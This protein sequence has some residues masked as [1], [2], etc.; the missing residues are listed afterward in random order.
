MSIVDIYWDNRINNRKINESD[1]LFANRCDWVIYRLCVERPMHSPF[2]AGANGG[3]AK[4]M[5]MLNKVT[6]SEDHELKIS[7]VGMVSRFLSNCLMMAPEKRYVRL[8]QATRAEEVNVDDGDKITD[9]AISFIT[10]W[11]ELRVRKLRK[12]AL[13]DPEN[14]NLMNCVGADDF[15]SVE[16]A[17]IV[18]KRIILTLSDIAITQGKYYTNN[19]LD[20]K[21]LKK[22]ITELQK[23]GGRW[24]GVRLPVQNLNHKRIINGESIVAPSCYL[25]VS[26]GAYDT[27]ISTL[28]GHLA[29]HMIEGVDINDRVLYGM[30]SLKHREATYR[31]TRDCMKQKSLDPLATALTRVFDILIDAKNL[32]GAA[33]LAARFLNIYNRLE[34]INK[35]RQRIS[36]AS[37]FKSIALAMGHAINDEIRNSDLSAER[38]QTIYSIEQARDSVRFL[39]PQ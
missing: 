31:M 22:S 18:E 32:V 2:E 14:I 25:P 7:S 26:H 24:S 20:V 6:N 30:M 11:L 34:T 29:S 23:V 15:C 38:D 35:K 27:W 28:L 9:D 8:P 37:K 5:E 16:N 21:E 10:K 4:L 36:W 3:V 39:F 13:L 17:K 1:R 12:Q 33:Q 19:I